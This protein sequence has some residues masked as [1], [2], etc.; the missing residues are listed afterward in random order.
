MKKCESERDE[1]KESR[2][3]YWLS[4][5]DMLFAHLQF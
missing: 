5:S 4:S 2:A 3:H 1:M